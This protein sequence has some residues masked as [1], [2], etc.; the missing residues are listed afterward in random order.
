MSTV[1][2]DSEHLRLLS[3]FH[4]IYAGV[5]AAYALLPLIHVCIG[6]VFLAA[7]ISGG[8]GKEG[9]P[10]FAG[11]LFILIGGAIMTFGLAHAALNFFAARFIAAREH[12]V[13][14]FVVAVLNCICVPLGTILG[15]FTIIVLTRES[16][17][18]LFG[19]TAAHPPPPR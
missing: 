6:T 12:Y 3:I 19:R 8:F 15:I 16:V 13:Y 17:K 9:P 14:C 2:R 4:Y 18:A 10:A 7:S 5:N 11:L 1:D